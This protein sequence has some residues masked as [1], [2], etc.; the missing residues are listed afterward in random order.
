MYASV[1]QVVCEQAVLWSL[2]GSFTLSFSANERGSVLLQVNVCSNT[3]TIFKKA[4]EL[5]T[6]PNKSLAGF[7]ISSCYRLIGLKVLSRQP[8]E[9]WLH[10]R[11]MIDQT[12]LPGFAKEFKII[13]EACEADSD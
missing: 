5:S 3:P 4:S 6:N 9:A 7:V 13:Y 10:A 1:G 2:D 11:M 8:T 12:H